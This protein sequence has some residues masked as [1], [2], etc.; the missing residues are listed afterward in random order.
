MNEKTRV[1]KKD[2]DP[3]RNKT[4]E[5]ARAHK[6]QEDRLNSTAA[7]QRAIAAPYPAVHPDDI[8]TLQRTVGNRA[9]RSMLIQRRQDYVQRALTS[10]SRDQIAELK[11]WDQAGTQEG[12]DVLLLTGRRGWIPRVGS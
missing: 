4:R 11:A 6:T 5:P 7:L 9:V 10:S 1:Q 12:P 2:H 8:T 3:R